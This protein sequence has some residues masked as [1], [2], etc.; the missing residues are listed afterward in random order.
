MSTAGVIMLVLLSAV[1]FGA[2][3]GLSWV[4]ARRRV[5]ARVE[6]RLRDEVHKRAA[7]EVLRRLEEGELASRIDAAMRE[8]LGRGEDRDAER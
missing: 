1:F 4:R 6:A 5:R 3:F 2:G 7:E 8:E